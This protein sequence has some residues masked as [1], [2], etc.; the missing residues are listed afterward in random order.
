MRSTLGDPTL[1]EAAPMAW[2]D[3][4]HQ[5]LRASRCAN[6]VRSS[7][8]LAHLQTELVLPVFYKF[9]TN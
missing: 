8:S 3:C 7:Y 2:F 9:M 1:R 4:A 6:A 5:P